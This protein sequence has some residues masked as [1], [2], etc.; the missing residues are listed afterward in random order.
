MPTQKQGL[1]R[2]N[3]IN[4]E[5]E[6]A[7]NKVTTWKFTRGPEFHKIYLRFL[8]GSTPLTK[9]QIMADVEK[10]VINKGRGEIWEIKG[11]NL[12]PIFEYY[13]TG[14]VSN[15]DDGILP[16][17]FARHWM[18]SVGVTGGVFGNIDG[19]ALGTSGEAVMSLEIH[20]ASSLT[21]DT[22]DGV[23]YVGPEQRSLG[24]YISMKE[25]QEEFG[26]T[27]WQKVLSVDT[28]ELTSIIAMHINKG[29]VT[30][31]RLKVDGD[32]L[33][34]M[35]IGYLTREVLD[36]GR[37]P[38]SGFTHIEFALRNRFSDVLALEGISGDIVIELKWSAAPGAYDFVIERAEGPGAG[39]PTRL[40]Q[41]A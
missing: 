41:A 30:D 7:A 6:H 28:D 26:S 18:E 4:F 37:T 33:I 14:S 38:Q 40:P 22:L 8:T 27:G 21:S 2:Q 23:T 11:A 35:P 3:I 9:D 19:P 12:I 17:Y 34:E 24:L 5:G 32:V 15:G 10:I 36:A 13:Q 39:Q 20:W 29:T 16:L 25:H 1:I 31:L